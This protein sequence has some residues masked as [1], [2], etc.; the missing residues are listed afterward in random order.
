MATFGAAI[1]NGYNGP[2]QS[3]PD[4]RI[5]KMDVFEDTSPSL[6]RRVTDLGAYIDTNQVLDVELKV[7][8]LSS[9][10]P[11]TATNTLPI[12]VEECLYA[13]LQTDNAWEFDALGY[14]FQH[15]VWQQLIPSGGRVYRLEYT[16]HV[17]STDVTI[18]TREIVLVW[19]LHTVSRYGS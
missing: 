7:F 12:G 17:Q 11:K 10:T 5:I 18:P 19:E 8:D 9:S 2:A 4:T 15:K 13:A 14:N 1:T 6:M 3:A 16:I